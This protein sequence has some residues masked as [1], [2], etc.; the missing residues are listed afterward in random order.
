MPAPIVANTVRTIH[1]P[2]AGVARPLACALGA[3]EESRG[4]EPD[5]KGGGAD[6]GSG[7]GVFMDLC[8]LRAYGSNRV[9]KAEGDRF[10]ERGLFPRE[11]GSLSTKL[12]HAG[13]PAAQ[14]NLESL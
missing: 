1:T 4:G 3:R 14:T 8:G 7:G 13:R 2:S 12:W 5:G 6:G 11:R 10:F 9:G